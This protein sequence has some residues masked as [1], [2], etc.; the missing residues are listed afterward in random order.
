MLNSEGTKV[1]AA[2]AD[3]GSKPSGA[4]SDTMYGMVISVERNVKVDG[5]NYNKYIVWTGDNTE[6]FVKGGTFEK[7]DF[8]YFDKTTDNLYASSEV[9]KLTGSGVSAFIRVVEYE[10]EDKVLTYY[11]NV[12]DKNVPV[13]VDSD[14]VIVYVDRANK[15][16][17]ETVGVNRYDEVNDYTNAL[18]VDI[19]G[20]HKIDAIIVD[21]N[22]DIEDKGNTSAKSDLDD[23][24]SSVTAPVLNGIETALGDGSVQVNGSTVTITG[25]S[26]DVDNNVLNNSGL[27][28][29]LRDIPNFKEATFKV[30]GTAVSGKLTANNHDADNATLWGDLQAKLTAA[31]SSKKITEEVT[32]KTNNTQTSFTVV[33]NIADD[34]N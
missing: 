20:D 10:S 32:V 24:I 13:A 21:E 1:V 16:A 33:I 2:F 23:A 30:N 26:D 5:V 14:V 18:Y 29:A 27:F 19:D 17:G 3:L 8:V 9:T 6:V 11:D 25:A 22:R 28:N 31:K 7:G 15:T 34:D 12:N 4:A